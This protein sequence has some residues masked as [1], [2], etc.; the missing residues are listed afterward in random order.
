MPGRKPRLLAA[1][2]DQAAARLAAGIEA[3]RAIEAERRDL[4]T[5]ISTTLRTPLA[6]LRATVG[7]VD[8][9]IVT[10]PDP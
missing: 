2:L 8:D 4:M 6:N 7:A 10:D 5:S 9:G 1:T 3:E